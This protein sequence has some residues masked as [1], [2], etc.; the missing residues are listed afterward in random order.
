M[1]KIKWVF[2]ASLI[3]MLVALPVFGACGEAAP[4]TTPTT[5]PTTP[6][7]PPPPQVTLYIGGD[8]ALTGAFAED[9]AAILA[10]FQDYAKYVNETHKLAPWRTETFPTNVTLEV[11]YLDDELKPEKA[12]TNYETL[13]AQG[14]MVERISGSVIAQALMDKMVTDNIGATSMASGPYLLT[15]PKTIFMNYPIYT[16]QCA[17]IA[18]WFME[19]WK[20]AGKTAK[21]RVAYFT[22]DTFGR[23]L[24]TPEMD[25]YLESIGYEI[26]GTQVIPQVPTTPPTTALMW[27]KDNNVD[28]TLGA[29]INPGSQPTLLEAQRLGMGPNLPYKITF[30]LCS[31]SHLAVYVRDMGTQGDGL[32]VAGSYPTWDDPCDGMVF[33]NELQDTY[34]PDNRVTHIMYPHGLVEAMIQVEALRLAMLE[35]PCDELTSADVLNYGFYKITNLDTGGIIPT[36]LTYGPA[37][38]EGADEVRVDQAQNGKVVLLGTWPLHHIYTH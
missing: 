37:D 10:A 20:A 12:L 38:V 9:C 21:P 19:N 28:L 23:S 18:D 36:P 30:G 24:L 35:V 13:K 33:A 31:P 7:T 8:F 14:L 15:P 34:R 16:D 6:T 17:A 22:N 29:M 5:P 32:V 2:V 25:A 3:I 26:V 11:K 27:L 4:T 1:A